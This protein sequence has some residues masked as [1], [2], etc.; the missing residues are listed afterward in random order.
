MKSE[1]VVDLGDEVEG[2]LADQA[3]NSFNGDRPDLFGLGFGVAL[4]A[5]VIG[6]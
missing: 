5:G 1:G 3:A 4:E 2:D 6:H